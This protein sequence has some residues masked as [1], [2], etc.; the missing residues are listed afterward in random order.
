[1]E[2]QG[3]DRSG[4]AAPA[5]GPAESMG[6]APA[7]GQSFGTAPGGD[8]EFGSAPTPGET[9]GTA[10]KSPTSNVPLLLGGGIAILVILGAILGFVVR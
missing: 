8:G 3:N 2:E 9:M 5:G 4:P 10:P 6:S 1:M 7:P